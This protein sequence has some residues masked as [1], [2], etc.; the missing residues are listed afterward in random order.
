MSLTPKEHFL[1]VIQVPKQSPTD[2]RVPTA[3]EEAL[4][5]QLII[6]NLSL[7]KKNGW[8]SVPNL[9][10]SGKN[11][12]VEGDFSSAIYP[13]PVTISTSIA[14]PPLSDSI[15]TTQRYDNLY[16]IV[17][18]VEMG[19]AGDPELGQFSFQYK[20]IGN[21]T[22]QTATK[23]NTRR[24]AAVYGLLLSQSSTITVE[25]FWNTLTTSGNDRTI[26]ITNTTSTGFPFGNYRFY[27]T[28][29]NLTAG[30][31]YKVFPDMVEVVPIARIRRLQEANENGYLWGAGGE[32]DFILDYHL[33]P[34]FSLLPNN[35]LEDQLR[36]RL[37]GIFQGLPGYKSCYKRAVVNLIAGSV[38]GSEHPGEG[39]V[40][41]NGSVLLANDQR[42]SFTNEKR[43]HDLAIQRVQ[44]ANDGNGV[45]V[46]T[47]TLNTNV[48]NGT[49]FSENKD[50]H[51]VFD[52]NGIEQTAY[53]T[54]INLGSSTSLSWF[55]GPN[56]SLRPNDYAIIV[57][58]IIYPAG[59]GFAYNFTEVEKVWLNQ[60]QLDSANIRQ[61]QFN[62][63]IAYE[64]PVNGNYIV[65][66]GS[67]RSAIHYIYKKITVTSSAT[68]VLTVPN[69]E[70]GCFA[71]IQ[72]VSG[73]INSPIKTGL[74]ANTSYNCLVYYPPRFNEKWQFQ[75]KLNDY[76]GIGKS[77][78]TFLQG[79]EIVSSPLFFVH[80]LGGGNS[81][82]QGE[83]RVR[84]S[85][86]GGFTPSNSS[87]AATPHYELNSPVHLAGDSYPGPITFQEQ[88]ILPG[89]TL[90]MPTPGIV[91]QTETGTTIHDRSMRVRLLDEAGQVIGCR[92]PNF[93]GANY[94]YQ[95][96]IGMVVQKEE[97][98]KLL[99]VT[100]NGRATQSLKFD[101]DQ[102][103]AIDL[104][105]L[106]TGFK[107][108]IEL[109]GLT[110]FTSNPLLYPSDY[111]QSS[112]SSALELAVSQLQ[113]DTRQSA[114]K[115]KMSLYKTGQMT[116]HN[117][118][119]ETIAKFYRMPLNMVGKK[120]KSNTMKGTVAYW[121]GGQDGLN[122]NPQ[123]YSLRCSVIDRLVML[124]DVVSRA[125]SRLS[126]ERQWPSCVGNKVSFWTV[127]GWNDSPSGLS[128][129]IDRTDFINESTRRISQQLTRYLYRSIGCGT[130]YSG[131]H[132]GGDEGGWTGQRYTN[133]IEKID[134]IDQST[135]TT[136][137]TLAQA[138]VTGQTTAGNKVAAYIFGGESANVIK[139]IIEKF[140]FNGETINTLGVSLIRA[141]ANYGAFGNSNNIYII[142]GNGQYNWWVLDA[143]SLGIQK[144]SLLT[145]TISNIGISIAP[146]NGIGK[147]G[148]GATGSNKHGYSAGSWFNPWPYSSKVVDKLSPLDSN[149]VYRR[150][151][152][153]LVY[154][155]CEVPAI[156]DYAEGHS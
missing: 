66:T 27:A 100:Y 58:G 130:K 3:E 41:T 92:T 118:N 33:E 82:Y 8:L 78:A 91:L 79:S 60:V 50:D 141:T 129:T 107:E 22:V 46:V 133:K 39:G 108:T 52:L 5:S 144:F 131:Y 65:V 148:L 30:V 51:K 111:P 80:S 69:T 114:I 88:D 70:R 143:T 45:G 37:Y 140:S 54:F 26:T 134:F 135:N 38:I 63:L 57:P 53:G 75:I 35:D 73:R 120:I 105:E 102:G 149:E 40:A 71:F 74:G 96:V 89:K 85:N 122:Q 76:E 1:G 99:V 152:V 137:T 98:R 86:I 64:A 43:L 119:A 124:G 145:E 110:S 34:I 21:T 42:Y 93:A 138:K 9:S 16:L 59:S 142:G 136:S 23:E 28:D 11:V 61:G 2:I 84:F 55:A 36:R 56:S 103:A 13:K 12:T 10:V 15:T 83:G 62:D 24:H 87:E 72:G 128:K 68:G 116:I 117:Q 150:L 106:N 67:E 123:T 155:H 127:G 29:P 95:F 18:D 77:Q 31:T 48:P 151:G 81:V 126:E 101:T 156:S 17:L 6:R 32:G 132:F 94:R 146:L 4:D 90:T 125:G 113:V 104:F 112:L 115:Q 19:E 121:V 139:N 47:A 25:S 49:V 147:V 109:T 14:I 97:S 153:S 7:I 154:N 20:Q 44:V